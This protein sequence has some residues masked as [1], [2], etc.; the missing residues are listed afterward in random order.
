M[1]A[2]GL[3]PRS[4][5][6]LKGWIRTLASGAPE[7]MAQVATEYR[8]ESLDSDPE[9]AGG[10]LAPYER[11]LDNGGYRASDYQIPETGVGRLYHR[12]YRISFDTTDSPESIISAVVNDLNRFT[13]ST[14]AR[15]EKNRGTGV[16]CRTGD[17]Y[18]IIITGPWNGPVE[19]A[20]CR[21]GEFSF[22]TLKGH[23]E[24]GFISFGVVKTGARRAQFQIR[25]WATCSDL[26]VW[27]SYTVL[28]LSRYMQTKMWRYF[29][30]KVVQ[31]FGQASGALQV[32][33][34]TL[35][36]NRDRGFGR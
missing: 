22:V 2:K 29:C 1:K 26:L 6:A 7:G 36:R 31:E 8:R 15:F 12:D 11:L 30:L 17:R 32:T 9:K 18:D 34:Y 28:G 25:S 10:L 16:G 4:F 3:L 21:P 24:S 23:L 14:L 35:A 33:T 20:D 27:F 13:N 5:R 19:V